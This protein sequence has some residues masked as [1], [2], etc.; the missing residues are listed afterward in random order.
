M[1]WKRNFYILLIAQTFTSMGFSIIFPFLPFY[2]KE[3][4]SVSGLSIETLSGLV[5]SSQALA[6]ALI[7]PFWGAVADRYGKKPMV[8]R[9]MV[10]GAV[11]V[12]LMGFV[13]TA[14]QLIFLRICQGLLSG[15][16]SATS[17]LAASFT[18]REKIGFTMGT[19]QVGV[20]TGVAL[21][22][23]A[24]GLMAD[25][26]GFRATFVI[27]GL[28]L[29]LSGVSVC[30]CVNKN[31]TEKKSKKGEKKD[32]FT[33]WKLILCRKNI[34]V[35]YM[36]RFLSSF[37]NSLLLPILPLF[38]TSIITSKSNLGTLTG[39]V[40]GISSVSGIAGGFLM[41]RVCDKVGLKKI[42]FFASFTAA[43]FFIPQSIV[44]EYWQ[45]ILLN[46]LAGLSVGALTP[47][48]SAL[49]AKHSD[50]GS[51]GSVYGFDNSIVAAG[52][53]V[54]P[55]TGSFIA[56]QLNYQ[57]TFITVGLTFIVI[58]ILTHLISE[59]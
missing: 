1:G 7:S 48:L 28:L 2:I 55:I 33:D 31:E 45:L 51:E 29:F 26:F 40:V 54:A 5:F 53:A 37:A 19:L 50:K 59:I 58:A 10:G 44:S 9:A 21:G 14:E 30:I 39:F 20:W 56:V 4:D 24:G 13:K 47:S 38:V 35:T 17:A 22:P 32:L 46:M 34:V 52:R 11:T 15:V 36:L 6:M 16:I 12:L 42:I 43:M 3:L 49:L 23:L 57:Y 27:T 18:P 25:F 8:V 41:S